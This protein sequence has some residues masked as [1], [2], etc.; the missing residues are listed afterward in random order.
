MCWVVFA[1]LFAL[2]KF[3]GDCIK[4]WSNAPVQWFSKCGFADPAV[5]VS[6]GNWLEMHNFRPETLGVDLAI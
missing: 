3:P 4:S 2:V 1:E 6:P 5:S